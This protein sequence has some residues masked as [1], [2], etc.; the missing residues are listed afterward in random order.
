MIAETGSLEKG[1]SKAQWIQKAESVLKTSYP[2]VAAFVYY[3]NTDRNQSVNWA[4]TSSSP[5]LHA[6]RAM[7]H[8]GYWNP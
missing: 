5:A 2:A 1:G 8:D 3:N 6:Y 4:V 7:G